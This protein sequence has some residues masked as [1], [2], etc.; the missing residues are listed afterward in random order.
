L[1][2]RSLGEEPLG[3]SLQVVLQD[4]LALDGG[5]RLPEAVA[6]FFSRVEQL[7]RERGL[8]TAPPA[9]APAPERR[10]PSALVWVGAVF[11]VLA[12]LAGLS[13]TG[14]LNPRPSP[15]EQAL[16]PPPPSL[17][18]E[19]KP[20]TDLSAAPGSVVKIQT[21]KGDIVVETFDKQAPITAGNFLLLVKAGF[22]NGVTF[23]RVVPDFVIQGGDP[24]GTGQGGPGFTIPDE[25]KPDLKHDRGMLSMAKTALPNTAGSQFFIVTGPQQAVS[26]LDMKHAVFG[27]VLQGMDVADKIQVGDKMIKVT[28]EKESPDAAAAMAA[29]EKAR[30]PEKK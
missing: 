20:M 26:H 18:T 19:E 22:Y 10:R 29:A 8:D 17:P 7:M 30:V 11:V 9:E 2:V 12:I 24:T 16:L 5:T 13:F 14:L 3:A 21:N 4:L 1:R 25:L 6:E 28:I 23:H 15:K 27:K